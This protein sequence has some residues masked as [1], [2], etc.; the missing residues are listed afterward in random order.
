MESEKIVPNVQELS[1]LDLNDPT[2]V[3][4][5]HQAQESDAADRQLTIRQAIKKYKKACF[6]AMFLSTSLIMEGYDLVIVCT[7]FPEHLFFQRWGSW[8]R[9]SHADIG[10]TDHF[11]L[12]SNAVP[13]SIWDIQ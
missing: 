1:G 6:W 2:I 3:E 12:R 10:N 9:K 5:I 11:F 4:L 8:I 13:E 7:P